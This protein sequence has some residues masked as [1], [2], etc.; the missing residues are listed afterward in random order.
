MTQKK[1]SIIS[2]LE[3]RPQYLGTVGL[4]EYPIYNLYILD[5]GGAFNLKMLDPTPYE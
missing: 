4:V 1:I 5:S 3:M 2:A